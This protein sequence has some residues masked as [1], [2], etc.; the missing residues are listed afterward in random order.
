MCG[1]TESFFITKQKGRFVFAMCETA[2]SIE[3]A[4][5]DSSVGKYAHATPIRS[6][7]C[8]VILPISSCCGSSCGPPGSPRNVTMRSDGIL[9]IAFSDVSGET[10]L[11]SPEFCIITTARRPPTSAPA[12]IAT[13]SP[14]FAAPM[15]ERSGASM[16]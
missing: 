4:T 5:S 13:A 12:A 16:T 6:S 7:I 10:A 3:L 14:S 11:P 8:V 2:L 9:K 15:Y 1:A